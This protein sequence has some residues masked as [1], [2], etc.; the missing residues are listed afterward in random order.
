MAVPPTNLPCTVLHRFSQPVKL[1]PEMFFDV[2]SAIDDEGNVC[3]VAKNKS[4]RGASFLQLNTD[5]AKAVHITFP[6]D[7]FVTA[8]QKTLSSGFKMVR[9]GKF[10]R[11]L[12]EQAQR[13]EVGSHYSLVPLVGMSLEVYDAE[14][15]RLGGALGGCGGLGG[16]GLGGGGLGGGGG[17][18]G[19]GGNWPPCTHE[20][21]DQMTAYVSYA[22]LQLSKDPNCDT[23]TCVL[24]G[25]HYL[26]I[27]AFD[28]EF[29]ALLENAQRVELALLAMQHYEHPS[30]VITGD[31]DCFI[32]R[33]AL[34]CAMG[35]AKVRWSSGPDVDAIVV[36][37][38]VFFLASLHAS[39]DAWLL[40]HH[41]Y[42]FMEH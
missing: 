9:T 21:S 4:K 33:E 7:C 13:V 28:I 16:G 40:E 25:L 32:I 8:E 12:A 10:F 24:A 22:L 11:C 37:R 30:Q 19:E 26:D 35:D 36:E 18:G 3:V 2:H 29:D 39:L 17:E 15:Q 41:L 27:S 20:P 31:S 38:R 23:N 6:R 34:A 1:E 42:I 5:T 14:I